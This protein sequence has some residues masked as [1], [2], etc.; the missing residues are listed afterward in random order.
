MLID[1]FLDYVSYETTS[2]DTSLSNP[3]SKIQLELGKHLYDCLNDLHLENVCFDE[4]GYVYGYLPGDHNMPTIGLCSHMDTS[5]DAPG[6]DI[7]PRII[8]NYDGNDIVLNET[9]KTTVERFP[10]LPDYKGK[11]LVVTDGATLLGADDKA[12]IACIM[13]TLEYFVNHPEINH[14]PIW[15]CFT[16][17]EEVGRGTE[18][19]NYDLFKVDFAYTCDGGEPNFIEY[20]N[21]NAASAVVNLT[22]ISVHPGSAKD[23]MVN[24]SKLA[25]EFDSYLDQNMV[26]EHTEGYEGFNHCVDIQ[27]ETSFGKMAY[28]LRNHDM[29]L[30]NKQKQSFIDIQNHMN[31]KYGYECIKVDIKDS[32]RNMKECFENKMYPIDLVKESMAKVG[33]DY[34]AV[35]IRGGTD[36]ANLTWNGILCPNLGTGGMNFH[37]VHEFWCK[38][39][40]EKVVELLIEILTSA[41]KNRL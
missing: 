6:K 17:D 14:C 28:I 35:A 4:Y 10:F 25:M 12:G 8:E 38:E 16:P 7:K 5:P 13:E 29:D 19:F 41:Q 21:F 15:V 23:K 18:K 1:K 22:G 30:L 31:K 36:G 39:D 2:D 34:K 20:E 33:L 40:G 37:G 24:A 26:P 32:Y 11:T 3:S 27:T 9:L